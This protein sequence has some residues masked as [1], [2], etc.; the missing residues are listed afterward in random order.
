M[1]PKPC[2]KRSE[3]LNEIYKCPK[4]FKRVFDN[5]KSICCDKCDK[6]YHFKC[7]LLN[8]TTFDFLAKNVNSIWFCNFCLGDVLPFQSLTDNQVRNMFSFRKHVNLFQAVTSSDMGF[9]RKCNVCDTICSDIKKATP[10]NECEHLIHRNCLGLQLWQTTD[11]ITILNL[12]CCM[13]CWQSRF[14]FCDIENHE[15]NCAEF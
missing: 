7:S 4:R 6:W 3:T 9:N 5:Q 8:R 12:W 1:H 2:P 11:T 13:T 14:P 10:C 15:L